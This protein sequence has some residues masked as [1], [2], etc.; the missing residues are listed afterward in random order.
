[1]NEKKEKVFAIAYL[2]PRGTFCEQAAKKFFTFERAKLLPQRSIR[3]VFQA[4]IVDE[5]KY[6]VVPVE[7]SLDGSVNIT[8]DLLLE[9]DLTVYGEVNL[10]IVH[11]L[12]VKKGARMNQINSILSHAQALAQCRNFLEVT[13]PTAD[14]RAVSSTA[15]AVEMVRTMDYTAAIGTEIAAKNF[16][17]VVLKR[18]IEDDTNNFTRFFVL[19]KKDALPTNKDK[20]SL[21]F[22]AKHVPGSLYQCLGVF[23]IRHINLTKI[24]SRPIKGKPWEYVFYLDFE[25]HRTE[26]SVSEALDEL[27]E[28]CTFVKILGSYPTN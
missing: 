17:L 23:A 22:S 28:I 3:H 8:L 10:R 4:V 18:Q 14:V 25:G 27:K 20:T 12:I 19:G 21:I 1:V 13:F 16:G 2:G 15:K 9:S 6:G 11:N 7:N 24:E 5:A 26:H